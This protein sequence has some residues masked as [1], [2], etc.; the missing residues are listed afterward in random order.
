MSLS[1]LDVMKPLQTSLNKAP[2]NGEKKEQRERENPSPSQKNF[3]SRSMLSGN[4]PIHPI[5]THTHTHNISDVPHTLSQV[6]GKNFS[7]NL[8]PM[9][10]LLPL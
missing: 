1:T 3:L 7:P 6:E 9:P 10:S 5:H 4:E 2:R 8:T